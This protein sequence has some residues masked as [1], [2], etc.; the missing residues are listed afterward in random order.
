MRQSRC[1]A[2]Y[3]STALVDCASQQTEGLLGPNHPSNGVRQAHA[4]PHLL[5][6]LHRHIHLFLL[7]D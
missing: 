1:P 7:D 3:E 2:G 6:P 4:A 5:L